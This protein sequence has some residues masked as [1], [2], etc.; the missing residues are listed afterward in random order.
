MSHF[1]LFVTDTLNESIDQQ[2]EPYNENSHF[3]KVIEIRQEHVKTACLEVMREVSDAI[4]RTTDIQ[5]QQSM[6]QRL[7]SYQK[8]FN[9]G[10]YHS[11]IA[12]WHGYEIDNDGNYYY[13]H[14]PNAK[15]DWYQVG[16]R[17]TG[18]LKL[19]DKAKDA[20]VI[21]G[22][23]NMDKTEVQQLIKNRRTDR[24]CVGEIDWDAMKAS[25]DGRVPFAVLDDGQWYERGSMGWWGIVSDED[26]SWN[27]QFEKKLA[28]WRKNRPDMEITVVD[29][30]I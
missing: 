20:P 11:I 19:T 8:L 9:E 4:E 26:N 27:E 13:E 28:E 5:H 7:E 1:C 18:F 6:Q 30:H 16:G 23:F 29:I 14:N 17:W 15:W 3:E 10:N 12:T 2:L 21:S 25:S 24:A 22:H